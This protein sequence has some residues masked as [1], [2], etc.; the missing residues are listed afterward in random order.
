MT[1]TTDQTAPRHLLEGVRI[2]DLST[3]LAAPFAAT[4]CADLG[5]TV[6]K[7]ELPD[8]SDALRGLAPTTPEHALYWKLINRN[9]Q[10]ITLDVRQ[11][12]GRALLLKALAHTDVLVENFR[13]GTLDKWQLDMAT[14]LQANPRL[15]VLRVTGFGQT[16][17]YATR[18]GFARIFEAMSGLTHLIGTPGSGPQHPNL[19]LGDLVTG[20]FGA[21]SIASAMAAMRADP[22]RRGFDID[23]SGTEALMRLLDPLAV[24]HE[25]LGSVRGHVG[26]RAGYTAPSNMYR[27]QDGV[28]VTVVASSDPIFRRLCVAMGREDWLQDPRFV[29]NPLRCR[30]VDALDG[31]IAEWFSGRPYAQVA[32]GLVQAEVPFTRVY[33]IVDVLQDPQVQHRQSIMRLTDPE[34]GTLPAP[35][36]VPRVQGTSS[37][38]HRSGPGVGEHNVGF[39]KALGLA[40]SELE[41]LK[42]KG[43]V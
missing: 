23:L 37:Q 24:E 4:L 20:V 16:G 18:P 7:V 40:P 15:V 3:V 19:P 10:G 1:D 6:T 35:C 34:L 39:Y 32:E 2:L 17:P 38:P 29:S 36:V 8:G 5:A 11:P 43:V 33:T 9:K 13:T 27:T 31:G 26:N 12:E 25:L 21:F 30:H 14:L 42:A 22:E 28:W 41:A